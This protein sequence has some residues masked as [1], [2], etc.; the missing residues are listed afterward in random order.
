MARIWYNG[1]T[2]EEKR[3]LA[4]VQEWEKQLEHHFPLLGTASR[5][6]MPV[7]YWHPHGFFV[8]TKPDQFLSAMWH[9]NR[10]CTGVTCNP[11]I[12]IPGSPQRCF[13][14]PWR[15]VPDDTTKCTGVTW[16]T[17]SSVWRTR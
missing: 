13:G 1:L 10:T 8:F 11:Y 9:Q 17:R 3:E 12:I 6:I 15:N 4:F 7:T 5:E 14:K 2:G 16:I